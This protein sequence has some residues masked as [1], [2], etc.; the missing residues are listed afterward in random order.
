MAPGSMESDSAKKVLR[1]TRL[2]SR[3]EI[4]WYVTT[5]LRLHREHFSDICNS[6]EMGID[7]VV[8]DGNTLMHKKV[9]AR[10]ACIFGERDAIAAEREYA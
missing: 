7:V 10:V 4:L 2:S 9:V 5:S 3:L 1:L 8:E 6:Q